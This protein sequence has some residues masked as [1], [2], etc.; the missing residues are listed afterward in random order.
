MP[1][2]VPT[3]KNNL[4]HNVSP[5]GSCDSTEASC[6]LPQ[7]VRRAHG[8]VPEPLLHGV[9][10]GSYVSRAFHPLTPDRS[11]SWTTILLL[12]PHRNSQTYRSASSRSRRPSAFWKPRWFFSRGLTFFKHLSVTFFRNAVIIHCVFCNF[13]SSCPP[14]PGW[15]T[16]RSMESVSGNPPRPTDLLPPVT[17]TQTL[18]RHGPCLRRRWTHTQTNIIMYLHI[19]SI[20]TVIC[21]FHVAAGSGGS[22]A[23]RH[24]ESRRLRR[25]RPDGGQ[26]P[27]LRALPEDGACGKSSLTPA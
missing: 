5:S 26:G 13:L 23:R 6:R 17:S 18:Q 22:G 8:S 25:Q 15:R 12:S 9:R 11:H 10:R 3:F 24:S 16:S 14:F 7:P 21:T 4:F 20:V 1:F 19:L 27:A 2:L